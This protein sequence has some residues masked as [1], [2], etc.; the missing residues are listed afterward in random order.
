[1]DE[2]RTITMRKGGLPEESNPYEMADD[3]KPYEVHL[4]E[5]RRAK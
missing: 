2:S 1:M 5:L 4:Y 3:F